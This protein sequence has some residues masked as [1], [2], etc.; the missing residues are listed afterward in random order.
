ME[1]LYCDKSNILVTYNFSSLDSLVVL[2]NASVR[3]MLGYA[4]IVWND[5][6]LTYSNKLESKA[7]KESCEFVSLSVHS[8]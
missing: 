3:S 7:F 1:G 5:L 2:H 6:E 4:S 8:V